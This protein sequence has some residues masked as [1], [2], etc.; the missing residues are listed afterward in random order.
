M[1]KKRFNTYQCPK[2]FMTYMSCL[3]NKRRTVVVSDDNH[4]LQNAEL[5]RKYRQAKSE[6][7]KTEIR[8]TLFWINLKFLHE[9][10]MKKLNPNLFRSDILDIYQELCI[11]LAE[12]IDKALAIKNLNTEILSGKI[13]SQLM[14]GVN[15]IM[16]EYYDRGNY[17]EELENPDLLEHK[18]PEDYEISRT[19]YRYL[20]ARE[21]AIIE[22]LYFRGKELEEVGDK[23]GLTKERTRQIREKAIRKMRQALEDVSDETESF[24]K[25]RQE[26]FNILRHF[27]K[28]RW[29][30]F[31][32]PEEIMVDL[33]YL[34]TRGI[35]PKEFLVIS[36]K[37]FTGK[38]Y[39]NRVHYDSHIPRQYYGNVFDLTLE[40]V[41]YNRITFQFQYDIPREIKKLGG[42]KYLSDLQLRK[43]AIELIYRRELQ[44]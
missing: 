5:S 35:N 2:Q 6:S 9:I 12:G 36:E 34:E 38:S 39:Y 20:G 7:V 18:Y 29:I 26:I 11:S 25:F 44:L 15:R 3:E 8:E 42:S 17:F 23:F 24:I 28:V 27:P 33:E 43:L 31:E 32:N 16:R 13:W 19:L 14:T 1:N 37:P 40:A 41:T 10:F 4:V 30:V 22:E 21:E